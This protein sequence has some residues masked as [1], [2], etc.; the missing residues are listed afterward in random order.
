MAI[1]L[2]NHLRGTGTASTAGVRLGTARVDLES[3]ASG[4]GPS[5]VRGRLRPHGWTSRDASMD[6]A[7]ELKL[8]ERIYRLSPTRVGRFSRW[9]NVIGYEEPAESPPPRP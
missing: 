9:L 1:P 8:G 5:L 3:L 6:G 7:I 4:A 2:E